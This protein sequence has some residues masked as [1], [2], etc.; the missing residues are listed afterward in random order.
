ME[1]K[2]LVFSKSDILDQ[3]IVPVKDFN[4]YIRSI[5]RHNVCIMLAISTFL[6]TSLFSPGDRLEDV[7]LIQRLIYNGIVALS[8]Y[9]IGYWLLGP[10]ARFGAVRNIPFSWMTVAFFSGL[11]IIDTTIY[12][13]AISS[14]TASAGVWWYLFT[15]LIMIVIA[16]SLGTYYFERPLRKGLA[17]KPQNLPVWR[18]IP[19]YNNTLEAMLPDDIQGTI[20]RIEAQNQYVR[21]ITDSGDALLRMSL[22]HAQTILPDNVGIQ[23]HRS[24]W[25]RNTEFQKV[26]SRD[27]NPRVVDRNGQDFPISRQ[28]VMAVRDIIDEQG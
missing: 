15:T 23:I 26:I 12:I 3:V 5:Y 10:I 24:I 13:M 17:N 2:T 14:Q 9:A 25:M 7:T 6:F 8:Y 20:L 11:A 19:A 22:A 18:P 27:G 28:K 4:T 16:V 1:N 21:V